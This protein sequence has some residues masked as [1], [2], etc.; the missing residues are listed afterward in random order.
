MTDA[1]ALFGFPVHH[2]WSPFIHGMFAR[3][4]G[5]DMKYRLHEAPPERFRSDVAE[6]FSRAG[7]ASTSR[8]RTRAPRPISRTN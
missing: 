1:Y 6:F 3:Q 2:S 8:C 4:T 7:A 5:Q